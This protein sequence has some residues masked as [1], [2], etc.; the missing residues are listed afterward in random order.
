MMMLCP[1]HEEKK[2]ENQVDINR[3]TLVGRIGKDPEIQYTADGTGI[4]RFSVATNTSKVKEGD[5]W[6]DGPPDWH[7]VVAWGKLADRC[8]FLG[9]GELVYVEGKL[10]TR[11]YDKEGEKRYITEVQAKNLFVLDSGA[12]ASNSR[13]DKSN[14]SVEDDVPF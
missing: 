7:R 13:K 3:V 10:R 4:A 1:D 12:S 8:G 6:V 9:K 2:G 5:K 14:V 11:S